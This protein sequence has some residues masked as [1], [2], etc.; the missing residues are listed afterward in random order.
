MKRHFLHF[1]WLVLPLALVFSLNGCKK[2]ENQQTQAALD[3][4]ARVDAIKA[5]IRANSKG[6]L[7]MVELNQEQTITI[8]HDYDSLARQTQASHGDRN[9]ATTNTCPTS[10]VRPK[11]ILSTITSTYSTQQGYQYVCNYLVTV[12]FQLYQQSPFISSLTSNASISLT[13]KNGTIVY[14]A[15]SIAITLS[16]PEDDPNDPTQ[17]Q[18]KIS[19]TTPFISKSIIEQTAVLF[20]PSIGLYSDCINNIKVTAENP[21]TAI[22]W[23]SPTNPCNRMDNCSVSPQ[24]LANFPTFYVNGCNA[25]GTYPAGY[26]PPYH[27]FQY[28]TSATANTSAGGWIDVPVVSG[29]SS[30]PGVIGNFEV[31]RFTAP[32]PAGAYDFRYRNWT[33]DCQGPWSYIT[34]YAK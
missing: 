18:Y 12:P 34:S 15:N 32:V 3:E 10:N 7:F 13:D 27:Q 1:A 4:Q 11:G 28:R 5:N 22:A 26:I 16:I 17:F 29:V 8:N 21:G 23:I 33:A 25:A 24:D 31:K 19:F 9:V 20:I 30:V 6:P 14:S 2:D